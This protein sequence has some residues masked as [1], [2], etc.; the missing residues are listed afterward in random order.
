LSADR[1]IL[2]RATTDLVQPNGII[3][4]PDGQRLFVADIKASKTYQYEIRADGSL[5]N[6]HLVCAL[7]S[8]GMTLDTEGNLYLT[9]K[10]VT[11]FDQTGRQIEHIDVPER[12]T[13]NVS[14]GGR[15]HRT[16][17]ITASAGF[18]A[19]QMRFPGA[20]AAK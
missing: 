9:G 4:T 19:I 18:Y 16:L 8:D 7:G 5:T 2:R 20:N 1:K 6:K 15:G 12:W 11:V 17:F 3:G 10:G 13:A 14:F